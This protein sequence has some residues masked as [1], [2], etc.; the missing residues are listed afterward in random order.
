MTHTT[1]STPWI[2]DK[3]R[4]GWIAG[5]TIMI[6]QAPF[7]SALNRISVIC[8]RYNL[9]M[10]ASGAQIFHGTFD[11]APP[12]SLHF[13]KAF[14]EH[15][16]KEQLRLVF[17]TMGL[18]KKPEMDQYFG[19]TRMGMILS[20]ISLASVTALGEM[21]IQPVDTLRTM[22]YGTTLLSSVKTGTRIAHLYKGSAASG[23]TQFGLWVGYP[24]SERFWT[25]IVDQH[26]SVG[27][28]SLTGMAL[29]S[30]PQSLQ[31]TLPIWLP[32]RLKYEL[33]YKPDLLDPHN[34]TSRYTQAFRHIVETQGYPG[35]L[36]GL[37]PRVWSNAILVV[38]ANY[39][40]NLGRA[41]LK[42]H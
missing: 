32:L 36:R 38:G 2:S 15:L 33:Q 37:I 25:R 31:I 5:E 9:S 16:A 22:K 30:L 11:Q 7:V 21:A 18:V 23:A 27:S 3:M 39:L 14:K 41:G 42:S 8:A 20:D 35:I 19:S 40:L 29:T 17:K 1:Q 26:T 6:A 13:L 34:P 10:G 28:H 4:R 24:L 12:S